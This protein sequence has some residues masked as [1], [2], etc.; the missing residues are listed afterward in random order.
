[1]EAYGAGV[2]GAL[3][4]YE[5]ILKAKPKLRDAFHAIQLSERRGELWCESLDDRV[6]I[7]ARAVRYAKGFLYV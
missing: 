4:A 5:A 2:E 7:S 3:R 6:R 1:V